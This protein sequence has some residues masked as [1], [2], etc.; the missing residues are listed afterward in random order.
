[1]KDPAEKTAELTEE[2]LKAASGGQ[3][4]LGKAMA[5][6]KGLPYEVDPQDI[7]DKYICKSCGHTGTGPSSGQGCV[8]MAQ[9][10]GFMDEEEIHNCSTCQYFHGQPTVGGWLNP[11][12]RYFYVNKPT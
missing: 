7:C 11:T 10:G 12:C 5:I 9:F 8:F 4:Q 3:S 6:M 2:E 1:M